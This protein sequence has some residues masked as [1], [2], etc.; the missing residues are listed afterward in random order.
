MDDVSSPLMRCYECGRPIPD[1]AILMRDIWIGSSRNGQWVRKPFH[2]ACY[3]RRRKSEFKSV[4]PVVVL[5]ISVIV[6]GIAYN[7][8]H[9]T[10]VSV[11][12]GIV[13]GILALRYLTR[14][15]G[16]TAF[17]N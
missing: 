14:P 17:L 12:I 10:T 8:I 11:L 13:V 15:R 1:D 6:S 7:V 9:D 3:Q 2:V 5:L 4:I 16:P